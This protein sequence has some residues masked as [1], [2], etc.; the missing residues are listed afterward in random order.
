M[1]R[2][3]YKVILHINYYIRCMYKK[4]LSMLYKMDSKYNH[5]FYSVEKWL[6]ES[7]DD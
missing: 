7:L 4:T 2:Y 5:Y 1:K 6:E 3:W